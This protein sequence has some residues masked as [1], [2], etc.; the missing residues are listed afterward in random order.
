MFPTSAKIIF[1]ASG[2]VPAIAAVIGEPVAIVFFFVPTMLAFAGVYP[3]N[4][5]TMPDMADV[6]T[7][8]AGIASASVGIVPAFR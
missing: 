8:F 1:V 7:A 5:G 6:A 2:V 3:A 4:V